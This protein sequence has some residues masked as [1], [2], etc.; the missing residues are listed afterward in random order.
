MNTINYIEGKT[1]LDGIS[2]KYYDMNST[3][4]SYDCILLADNGQILRVITASQNE[5]DHPNKVYVLEV[6]K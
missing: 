5:H 4:V 6:L 2:G 3:D 1:Y